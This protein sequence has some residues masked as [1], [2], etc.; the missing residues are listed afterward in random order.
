ML[1]Y[2][3]VVVR[4]AVC[5]VDEGVQELVNSNVYFVTSS[6]CLSADECMYTYKCV[7]MILFLSLIQYRYFSSTMPY[8]TCMEGM[9]HVV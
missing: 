4:P 5:G 8:V 7:Y 2:N 3:P 9:L 1:A 6:S